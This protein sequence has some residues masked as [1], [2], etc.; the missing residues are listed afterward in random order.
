MNSVCDSLNLLL[1]RGP[2]GPEANAP[3][4]INSSCPDGSTGS[5]HVDP[6][7][8][9]LS[10]YSVDGG[11]LTAGKDVRVRA[12]VFGTGPADT[13][14]LFYAD[15]AAQPNWQFFLSE[16]SSGSGE[17]ATEWNYTLPAG[18]LQAIRG[19]VRRGGSF[20][21]VCTTGAY[22]DHDDLVFAVQAPPDTTAPAVSITSPTANSTVHGTQ[23]LGATATDNTAVSRVDFLVDGVTV[24]S[25][26]T[27]PY[28]ANWNSTSVANGNHTIRARATDPNG[29]V[30]TSADVSFAVLNDSTPPTVTLTAPGAGATV[31]GSV[32]VTATATDNV[33]VA[34]V[35]FL[36]DGNGVATDTS[37][38]YSVTWNSNGVADGTHTLIA[39][40]TDSSGNQTSTTGR[41]INVQNLNALFVA[42]STTLS[43]SD[44]P[45]RDRLVSLGY[46]LTIVASSTVAATDAT[47]KRLV[48]VSETAD[49]TKMVDKLKS[50]SVGVLV[51]DPET[52][53][54]MG[55]TGTTSSDWGTQSSQTKIAMVNT[56]HPM[57]AGLT[58]TR[59]VCSSS[60]NIGWG[61]PANSST[62]VASV[63]G[64]ASK[65]TSFAYEQGA[66]MV[67]V[68]APAR[69]AG[70]FMIAG[71]VTRANTDAWKLFD[72]AANWA[73]KR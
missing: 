36:I 47:N 54:N 24:G 17:W 39:R 45:L 63:S 73:A 40:A 59:T 31:A 51:L 58:G 6:S 42:G 53:K 32:T 72:A 7:L 20:E 56:S 43:S 25:A 5:F 64:T 71:V 10:I 60:T 35:A 19:V 9:A 15:N 33:K 13:L 50:V 46:H 69:R 44:T 11:P 61:K 34:S 57:A 52:F 41:S 12:L 18:A 3:N 65:A 21:T 38:P 22:D 1:G 67:S 30:G 28:S 16:Q 2:L 48:V 29:N 66:S 49:A 4:T 14:D 55:M 8:D 26:T 23:A 62:I 27:A 37:S 68:T 70:L